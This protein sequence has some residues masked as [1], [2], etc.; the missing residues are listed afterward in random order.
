MPE[1]LKRTRSWKPVANKNNLQEKE[2]KRD[3]GKKKLD[4]DGTY[5]SRASP[6]CIDHK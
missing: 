4:A 3:Q 5:L 2:E 1:L 6:R